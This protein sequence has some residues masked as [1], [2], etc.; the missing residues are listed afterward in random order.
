M[1][2]VQT[3][4][5]SV[6]DVYGLERTESVLSSFICDNVEVQDFIRYK[7][8]NNENRRLARTIL[9]FD[10]D[11]GMQL[12]GFYSIAIKSLISNYKLSTSRKNKYFGTAQTNGNV[13]STQKI[14]DIVNLSK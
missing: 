8:I 1:S 4:L 5:K 10:K 3:S 7:A 9:L 11:S 12:V 2:I 13:I 6:I 14:I